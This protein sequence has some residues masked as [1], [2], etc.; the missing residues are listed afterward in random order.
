MHP[1][2]CPHP[3]HFIRRLRGRKEKKKGLRVGFLFVNGAPYSP[4]KV[5]VESALASH[6]QQ[7]QACVVRGDMGAEMDS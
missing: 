7:G 6:H 1:W 5:Y 3:S 4:R 2:T